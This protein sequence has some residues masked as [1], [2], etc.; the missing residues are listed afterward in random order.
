MLDHS[1][2]MNESMHELKKTTKADFL[3]G[4]ASNYEEDDLDLS[5]LKAIDE[6]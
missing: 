1:N 3:K 2:M 4:Q 5:F 6:G